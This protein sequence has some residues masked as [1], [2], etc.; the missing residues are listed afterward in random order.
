MKKTLLTI[1]ILSL[2]L[3]VMAQNPFKYFFKSNNE[4]ETSTNTLKSGMLN[5]TPVPIPQWFFKLD[6]SVSLLRFQYVGGTQGVEVSTFKM[7]GLGV[8]Y[9]EIKI[10]NSKNYADLTLKILLD[11]PTI[12]N[13]K[14]GGCFGVSLWDNKIGAIIGYTVDEKY[15]FLGINGSYNF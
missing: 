15:P 13:E 14:M 7:V 11:L 1:M 9:Q 12:N 2:S 5:T 4:I 8:S 10:V 6:G 3:V